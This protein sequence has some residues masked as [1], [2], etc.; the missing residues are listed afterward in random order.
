MYEMEGPHSWL[1]ALAFRLLGRRVP[2]ATTGA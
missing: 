1:T 2:H